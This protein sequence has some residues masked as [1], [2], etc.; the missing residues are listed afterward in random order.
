[1]GAQGRAL[2]HGEEP[3]SEEQLPSCF[4]QAAGR[5]HMS[6]ADRFKDLQPSQ[7][8]L[9]LRGGPRV[10]PVA[11][12]QLL[13]L[14]TTLQLSSWELGSRNCLWLQQRERETILQQKTHCRSHTTDGV[15]ANTPALLLPW[16][17]AQP[18][19]SAGWEQPQQL[20]AM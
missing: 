1:M 5:M 3:S 14:D 9:P 18:Q 17:L 15:W 7:F 8:M 13:L 6:G 16:A 20:P 10:A 2:L 19:G 4:R 11:W 12:E